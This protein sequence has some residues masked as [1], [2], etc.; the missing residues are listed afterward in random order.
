M[1]DGAIFRRYLTEFGLISTCHTA[2]LVK[3]RSYRCSL[4]FCSLCTAILIIDLS[5]I[6]LLASVQKGK[7]SPFISY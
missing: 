5:G 4:S 6:E 7:V 1:S 3:R 2:A